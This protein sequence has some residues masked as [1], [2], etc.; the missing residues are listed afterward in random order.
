MSM[1]KPRLP[2]GVRQHVDVLEDRLRQLTEGAPVREVGTDLDRAY[3]QAFHAAEDAGREH[4][5]DDRH[6]AAIRDFGEIVADNLRRLRNDAGWTQAQLAEA[7]SGV[8]YDWKR[9]TVAEVEGAT[10]KVSLEELLA[11]A[12]LYGVPMATLLVP[13]VD[14][15]RW[16]GGRSLSPEDVRDLVLGTGARIG[17]HGPDWGPAMRATGVT[18]GEDWRPAP[19]LGKRTR[20]GYGKWKAS[21]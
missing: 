9:I 12:A 15:L 3:Q 11:L 13:G 21:R 5:Y 20:L 4:K 17:D 14:Y 8:G 6:T 18:V 16:A 2:A 10:R 1:A 19:A 7:M